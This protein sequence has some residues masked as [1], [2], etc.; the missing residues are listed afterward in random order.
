MHYKWRKKHF[1]LQGCGVGLGCMMFVG[2]AWCSAPH[3]INSLQLRHWLQMLTHLSRCFLHSREQHICS[4]QTRHICT[5]SKAPHPSQN[6]IPPG[7]PATLGADRFFFCAYNVH[8][9]SL[10]FLLD[11]SSV[12]YAYSRRAR[13]IGTPFKEKS[14]GGALGSCVPSSRDTFELINRSEVTATHWVRYGVANCCRHTK[15]AAGTL[16]P[17][18]LS[19]TKERGAA[20]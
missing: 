13:S 3:H 4:P 14:T 10:P 17:L 9:R 5:L 8:A 15:F 19:L 6:D 16:P 11:L 18:S 12:A 20:P 1:F 7:T 2:A